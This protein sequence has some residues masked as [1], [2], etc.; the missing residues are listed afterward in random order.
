MKVEYI[1]EKKWSSFGRIE[2]KRIV[3][4]DNVENAIEFHKKQKHS[5]EVWYEIVVEYEGQ[6][7]I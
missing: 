7:G 4:F 5:Y 6:I 2:R 3:R 1:V